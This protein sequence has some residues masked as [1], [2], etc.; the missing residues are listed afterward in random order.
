[1]FRRSLAVMVALLLAAGSLKAADKEIKGKII[2]VDVKN[3]V[4]TVMTKDGPKE[5]DVN[6]ETKFIGPRGGV[7]AKRMQDDRLQPGAEVKLIVAGNNRTLRQVQL[8]IRKRK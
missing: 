5:F 6:K 4:I 3:N 8:P 1:M 7:S 2:K